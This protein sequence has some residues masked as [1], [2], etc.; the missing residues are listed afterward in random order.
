MKNFSIEAHVADVRLK[1]T[2]ITLAELFRAALEGMSS[3]MGSPD[4]IKK[5]VPISK[6]IELQSPD[7][8]VLLIDFLSDV[9]AL[10]HTHKALFHKVDF[11]VLEQTTLRA[12]IHGTHISSFNEDI[13]AVTYHEA[14]VE[15]N[16]QNLYQT[17]IVFDI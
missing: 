10:S 14:N 9:L 16:Q 7:V 12:T 2:G 15:K 1:V 17:T 3:I 13:K 6:T 5:E 8:T 4:T 11:E